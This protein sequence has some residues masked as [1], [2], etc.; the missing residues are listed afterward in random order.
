[1]DYPA[2]DKYPLLPP[3]D[4]LGGDDDP[5]S[6]DNAPNTSRYPSETPSTLSGS[7]EKKASSTLRLKQ[8]LK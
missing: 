8:K 5:G 6:D 2:E 1:M 7:I 3:D 4:D